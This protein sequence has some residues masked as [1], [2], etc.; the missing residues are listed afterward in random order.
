MHLPSGL[1]WECA[2]PALVGEGAKTLSSV[3]EAT[4]WA[5]CLICVEL[6]GSTLARGF[7]LL[8]PLVSR[9]LPLALGRSLTRGLATKLPWPV[10]S[11]QRL[12]GG[13]F[14]LVTQVCQLRFSESFR[15]AS[16]IFSIVSEGEQMLTSG[17]EWPAEKGLPSDW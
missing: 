13:E 8:S 9:G 16:T 1:V 17:L 14:Q 2:A 7:R 3:T 11:W 10:D 5:P 6:E 15:D 12:P 4:Y